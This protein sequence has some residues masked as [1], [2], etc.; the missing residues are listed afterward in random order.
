[1]ARFLTAL[2]LT[3]T[4]SAAQGQL[5]IVD[6]LLGRNGGA[7]TTNNNNNNIQSSGTTQ[8]AL[9]VLGTNA[10]APQPTPSSSS[11]LSSSS[12]SGNQSTLG[13]S[14][15]G[16]LGARL[17]GGSQQQGYCNYTEKELLFQNCT[18]SFVMRHMDRFASLTNR[19]TCDVTVFRCG[20]VDTLIRCV[21]SQPIRDV[22]NSCWAV[23][24]KTLTGF[25][26]QYNVPCTY[27]DM[28]RYCLKTSADLLP[29][30]KRKQK[31]QGM[32]TNPTAIIMRQVMPTIMKNIM[33]G[34]GA[35]LGALFAI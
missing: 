19:S 35:G 31:G 25:L 22:S 5:S 24:D 32:N 20:Q 7:G 11:S 29:I 23:V 15:G 3:L 34:G 18:L 10:L 33:G 1:M 17:S 16:G 28:K 26:D 21:N 14:V 4:L 6:L 9:S 12:S 30:G 27:Q 13:S 2:F 8:I